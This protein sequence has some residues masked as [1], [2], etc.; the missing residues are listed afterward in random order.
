MSGFD[1]L[2][3]LGGAFAHRLRASLTLLGIVI[4]SGSIVLLASLIVGGRTLLI[5][6]SQGITDADVVIV[7]KNQAPPDKQDKTQRPLSR[8]DQAE[9]ENSNSLDGAMV[10]SEGS[11]WEMIHVDGQER[12]INVVSASEQTLKLYRLSIDAGRMLDATDR[13]KGNRVCVIGHN[14]YK[15]LFDTKPITSGGLHLKVGD[16]LFEVVGALAMKPSMG[17]KNGGWN[18]DN[19]VLLP[20]TTFDATYGSDHSVSRIY[21]RTSANA[22]T[23]ATARSTVMSVLLRRHL[24]ILNFKLREDESGSNEELIL[25]TIQVLLLG[26]GL[27]ALLASGINIM[28]VMLVTVAER[29]KEIGLR[30]AIGAT[31]R[32]ILV[33]FLLEAAAL[34]FVGGG[35]GVASGA[36]LAW[37]VA[38]GA[39]ASLGRW[40]FALP[41][42]SMALGLALAVV[43]GVVFG[44]APA[45]RAAKVSPIDAL[46]GE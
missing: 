33:Q 27:L 12:W 26:T 6:Q 8:L 10:A 32:S 7:E 2:R 25:M 28:N 37:L 24:G 15:D 42:W 36:G 17:N 9:L 18:W 23:R 34:S 20:E 45:W 31:P 46:R 14:L 22:Q 40:N 35:L 13:E 11:H 1:L 29:R 19:K 43:T 38:L 5:D 39:R 3:S 30:R 41:A 16:E 44:I 21:V 4:G